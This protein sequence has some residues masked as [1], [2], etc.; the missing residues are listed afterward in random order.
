MTQLNATDL[1]TYTAQQVIDLINSDWELICS[2]WHAISDEGFRRRSAA[3]KKI[4][5]LRKQL[6]DAEREIQDSV[7]IINA[8][9]EKRNEMARPWQR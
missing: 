6:A 2:N 9:I 3:E 7:A 4:V 5:R 8:A 1:A